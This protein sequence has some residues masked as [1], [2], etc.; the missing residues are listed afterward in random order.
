M[1]K[2]LAEK[3]CAENLSPALQVLWIDNALS[4][5]RPTIHRLTKMS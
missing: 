5:A 2:E 4:E 3:F 1:G